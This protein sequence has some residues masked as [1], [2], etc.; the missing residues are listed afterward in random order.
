LEGGFSHQLLERIGRIE[1][2]DEPETLAMRVRDLLG[3]TIEEQFNWR[4]DNIAL[5][6][7]RDK[8][9]AV[10]I[11]VLQ[12]S[13]PI[14]EARAFSF[15]DGSIPLIQLNSSDSPKGRIFSLFHELGH[16]LLD[17]GGICD[18]FGERLWQRSSTTDSADPNRREVEIFCNHFA[19]AFL[20]PKDNLLNHR[21]VREVSRP[22]RWS[23][24]DLRK[25]SNDFGVSNEVLLRRLL[26]FRLTTLNYYQEKRNEWKTSA[27]SA[28]EDKKGG[29]RNVPKDCLRE[30]GKRFVGLVLDSHNKKK[31]TSIDV[32]DY[33][34][35]KLK[36]I[37]N[38]KKL[39]E[40]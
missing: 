26:R 23:D 17:T 14:E 9:E 33:L 8:I 37:Q 29:V 39:I 12:S 2:R 35:I 19:G 30:N 10:G 22:F 15:T 18:P 4:R 24:D 7:W 21:F 27:R 1:L 20:V 3:V 5:N 38:V 34:S 11:L 31:I 13:W 25:I 28:K 32:A 16:L 6:S 40:A 36:H